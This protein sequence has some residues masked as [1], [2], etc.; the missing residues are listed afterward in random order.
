MEL[1]NENAGD[2]EARLSCDFIGE[3]AFSKSRELLESSTLNDC[4]LIEYK[5]AKSVQ[6]VRDE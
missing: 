6:D 4:P 3:W 1:P 5:V 2:K